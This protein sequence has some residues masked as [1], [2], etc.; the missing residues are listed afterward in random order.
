MTTHSEKLPRVMLTREDLYEQVWQTPMSRLAEGYGISGNGLAKIC[1][2]LSVP[3]PPRGYWAKKAAGKPV[4][5]TPLPDARPG[6]PEKVTISPTVE[7]S[8][9]EQPSEVTSAVEEAR[10]KIATISVPQRLSRPHPVIARWLAEHERRKE[11][12]RREH[13]PLSRRILMPDEFTPVE[14]RQHRI[15]DALFKALEKAGA[16]I[17]EGERRELYA[18]L[19]GEKIVFRMREKQ[20][21]V[22][23]PLSE[24]EKQF[25]HPDD[26]PWRQELRST[27]RLA[28]AIKTGL[29]KGLKSDWTESDAQPF[30]NILPEIVATFVAATPLL[31]E[32]TRE[33]AEQAR[34]RQIEEH[35]RYEE[36]Q[37]RKLDDNQWRRLVELAERSREAITAREFIE[38][39]KAS[40]IDP[41]RLVEGRTVGEWIKWAEEKAMEV[42]PLSYGADT[43]F[44]S[45]ASVTTWTYRD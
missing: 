38:T 16:K 4:P 20:K 9:V 40:D 29:P 1:R 11:Q 10:T 14:R 43:I 15:L 24:R 26:K 17:H 27:G 44:D 37:H 31:A 33:R 19:Q 13:D 18:E 41:D 36:Q 28:F 39:I 12:A 3:Y 6:T 30:E 23:R 21:Q 35:K 22:R 45:I 7:E 5:N 8:A 42:D 2:R 25:S 32:R 34:L